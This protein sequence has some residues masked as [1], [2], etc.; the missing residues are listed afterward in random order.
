MF[1]WLL[2]RKAPEV[3]PPPPPTPAAQAQQAGRRQ[4]PKEPYTAKAGVMV[5]AGSGEHGTYAIDAA[6]TDKGG[7]AVIDFVLSDDMLEEVMHNGSHMPLVVYHRTHGMCDVNYKLEPPAVDAYIRELAEFNEKELND[8]S[9]FLDGTLPDGSRLNVAIPPVSGR[10]P[11]ITIRKF[12]ETMITV[13]DIV[14]GGGLSAEAAAFLWCAIEGFGHSAAN[15]LVVG[16]TGSGK[17]TSLNAMSQ[18]AQMH[19]RIVVIEDARELKITQPNA[20]RMG[21]SETVSMDDLLI[22]ALRQRPDRIIVG[23]VR[24][25]EARTLF[26]A[27][28]TGHDGCMGTLHAN[29]ARECLNRITSPPMAVPL[30]QVVGLDLVFVQTKKN[31]ADGA[32]RFCKEIS[33]VSG[34][35]GDTA[36]L[37]QLFVWDEFEKKL[38]STGIPSRLR[39]KICNAAGMSAEQFQDSLRRRTEILQQLAERR[40]N[41]KDFLDALAAENAKSQ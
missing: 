1:D 22:N 27:M 4:S 6:I 31:T 32:R 38:M 16:G 25:P 11:T 12:K 10:F 3:A 37:N 28:N 29:S 35:G 9:P 21:T 30:T 18:F 34:F 36:R 39:T 26:T 5:Y 14:R 19:H 40:V 41:E 8:K 33:E 20:L 13:P 23:E 15:M 24:G 7:R 17:T 2:G